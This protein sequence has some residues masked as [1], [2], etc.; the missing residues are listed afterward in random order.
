MNRIIQLR[1]SYSSVGLLRRD[2]LVWLKLVKDVA[3]TV[4]DM[5]VRY[6]Q[7]INGQNF[8]YL[9]RLEYSSKQLIL[10]PQVDMRLNRAW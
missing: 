1:Q 2:S 9:Y 7:N 4:K 5:P 6:L 3:R 10:L 8:E